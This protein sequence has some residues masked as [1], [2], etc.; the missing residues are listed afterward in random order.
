MNIYLILSKTKTWRNKY[1]N[2]FKKIMDERNLSDRDVERLTSVS[3]SS[4]CLIKNGKSFP[5]ILTLEKLAKGLDIR[6]WDFVIS[7]YL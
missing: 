5:N 6:I 3:K 4:V 7:K 1:G 2:Y